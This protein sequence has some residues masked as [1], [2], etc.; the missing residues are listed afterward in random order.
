[1][2]KRFIDVASI[3]SALTYEIRSSYGNEGYGRLLYLWKESAHHLLLP[4]AFWDPVRIPCPVID[5]RPCSYPRI[6]FVSRIKLDHKLADV[7][8]KRVLVPTG[9][10]IQTKS[11][12]A[13]EDTQGGILQLSCGR[14]KSIVALELI[15]RKQVP[16]IVL[17]DNTQLLYQWKREVEAC[18]DVPGGIGI[19][20]DGQKDWKKGLVLATYHS[21]ANWSETIPEEARRWFGVMIADEAHHIN[22]PVFS[23]A[24]DMFYGMRV[25]LTATPK[26]SDGMDVLAD[27]HIGPVVYKNLSP[28]LIPRFSFLWS[29]LSLDL[30]DPFV[31]PKVLDIN[32]E[33]HLS[34]LNG[35]FGQWPARINII[36]QLIQMARAQ[37]RV[38]LILS[39]SV[40]EVANLMNLWERPGHPLYTDIPIPTPADVGEQL[41]PIVLPDKDYAKVC[42]RIDHITDRLQDP[43]WVTKVGTGEVAKI[44][45]ELTLLQQA[46]K[47]HKIGAKI[48]N[49]LARRQKAYIQQL[50]ADSKTA[51]LLTFDVDTKVRQ[52]FVATRDLIFAI[53]K[54]GKEG[55]DCLRLD[56]VIL[57]SL[58]SDR[59]GLQQ[60][61]GRP[62]RP[63]PGKKTPAFVAIVDD[64]GPCIGM[65]KKL[66]NH[67]RSWPIEEGGPHEPI[68][69]GFPPS[70]RSRRTDTV[71]TIFGP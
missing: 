49:E 47:Q 11:V 5:C 23:R 27:G 56:T 33:V 34:K 4:R 35:F 67:L 48:N 54:Y 1:M 42:K 55:Y 38:V 46:I 29:G 70:W 30:R 22:A 41:T 9:N 64:I 39:N 60:L 25:G 71:A 66:M 28:M 68:L 2:P 51:G 6:I 53:T 21:I 18:L 45:A 31:A 13:L 65:A 37:N 20:G 69:L 61:I 10:D 32:G 59:N 8:G 43:R 7:N 17:L 50:V 12:K 57:S 3:K 52:R 40:D 16:A 62:T 36:L 15:A 19:Y 24:A 58:F 26:R 44:Q 63:L 14:G